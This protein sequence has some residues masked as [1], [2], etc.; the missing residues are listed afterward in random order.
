[1]ESGI[2]GSA[3]GSPV[4]STVPYDLLRHPI[5]WS[6]QSVIFGLSVCVYVCVSSP[7]E[8]SGGSQLCRRDD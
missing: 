7:P 1:M 3:A 4:R 6:A 2:R 8:E 5:A